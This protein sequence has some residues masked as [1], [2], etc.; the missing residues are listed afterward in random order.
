M[1]AA[2]SD[3]RVR[4]DTGKRNCRVDNRPKSQAACAVDL[5]LRPRGSM[6]AMPIRQKITPVLSA[7][8]G[9]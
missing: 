6:G 4:A 7:R 9:L 2:V 5:D 8:T 1:D 3:V